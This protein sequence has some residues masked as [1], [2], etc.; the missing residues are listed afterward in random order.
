LK[1]KLD[2]LLDTHC[3]SIGSGDLIS[4]VGIVSGG[5]ADAITEAAREGLDV[6]VTGEFVHQHIH[7]IEELGI[8]LVAAGHYKTEV[9]GVKGLQRLVEEK[10]GI[11]TV[12][13]DLPTGY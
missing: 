1:L 6:L 5:A 4:K 8:P 2:G 11:E 9:P 13:I 3:L 10:F 7:L 12:F